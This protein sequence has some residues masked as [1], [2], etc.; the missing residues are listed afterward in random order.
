MCEVTVYDGEYV[1][2]RLE[3]QSK[4]QAAQWVAKQ[5]FA[6]SQKVVIQALAGCVSTVG[7]QTFGDFEYA[8]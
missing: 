5:N 3:F 7:T 6:N 4:E 2:Q 8:E 1:V